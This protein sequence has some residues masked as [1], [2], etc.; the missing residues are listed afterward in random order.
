MPC[1][2]SG[3]A[4]G[5]GTRK[6]NR[7]P[8]RAT[9]RSAVRDRTA[10]GARRGTLGTSRSK[11]RCRRPFRRCAARRRR[12]GRPHRPVGRRDRQKGPTGRICRARKDRCGAGRSRRRP[13]SP[14]RLASPGGDRRRP[15]RVGQGS[16]SSFP[17]W[18][19]STRQPRC[20]ALA[21]AQSI[22]ARIGRRSRPSGALRIRPERLVEQLVQLELVDHVRSRRRAPRRGA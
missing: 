8:A 20:G 21:P 15:L 18:R 4:P 12:R 11:A 22:T 19:G 5:S 16:A 17:R 13:P 14:G 7:P 10:T 1:G 3:R 9:H 6:S 2:P